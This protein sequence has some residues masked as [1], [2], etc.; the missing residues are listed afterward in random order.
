[1]SANSEVSG[2]CLSPVTIG[3]K[4]YD[5][6]MNEISDIVVE[7]KFKNGRYGL[8]HTFYDIDLN[9]KYSIYPKVKLFNIDILASPKATFSFLC[10]DSNHPHAI[11][12]G[13]PS[14]KNGLVVMLTLMLQKNMVAIMLG[15]M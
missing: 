2:N 7:D 15:G 14:G 11:D 13:M 4:L 1:M 12:L 10:P 9:K 5:E 3:Y 8:K 6:E